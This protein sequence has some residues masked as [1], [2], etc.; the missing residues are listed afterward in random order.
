MSDILCKTQ[1]GRSAFVD[2]GVLNVLIEM[3]LQIAGTS[4]SLS[5]FSNSQVLSERTVS[6]VFL[7]DIWKF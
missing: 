4:T 5:G 1:N 2:S 7:V 3:A 6:M